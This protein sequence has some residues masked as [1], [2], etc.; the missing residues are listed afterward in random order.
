MSNV[1]ADLGQEFAMTMVAQ[2][3]LCAAMLGILVKGLGADRICWG[4][5]AVWSGSP[6]WQIEGL[7]RLEIPADMR[8]RHSFATL[9]PATGPVKSAIFAGNSARL[10]GM[11][12]AARTKVLQHRLASARAEYDGANAVQSPIWVCRSRDL[13]RN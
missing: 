12:S 5:D 6:Q 4:T 10:Y 9:G 2:P 1:Y 11:D 3:R 8:R 13:S 7:R